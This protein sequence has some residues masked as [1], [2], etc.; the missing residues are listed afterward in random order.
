MIGVNDFITSSHGNLPYSSSHITCH[1]E[2]SEGSI[3]ELFMT[4]TRSWP[5]E[6]QL[7]CSHKGSATASLAIA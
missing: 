1:P 4:Y 2:H 5:R 3:N 7:L 6:G